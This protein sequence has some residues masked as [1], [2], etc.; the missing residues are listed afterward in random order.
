MIMHYFCGKQRKFKSP[1]IILSIICSKDKNKDEKIFKEEPINI[2][3]ILGL[4]ENI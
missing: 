2:L 1:K 4:T 3:K